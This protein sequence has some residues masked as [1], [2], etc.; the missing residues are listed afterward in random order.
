MAGRVSNVLKSR[1]DTTQK[2]KQKRKAHNGLN[3]LAIAE[4]QFPTKAKVRAHRLGE[5]E[6]FP[7]RKRDNEDDIADTK[8]RRTDDD[9]ASSG[10][11]GSDSD[12][13]EWKV[14][15][16][17][18]DDDSDIDSDEA[19]GSSDEER[20]EDFTFRG[21]ST[22]PK[23]KSK[24]KPN[25]VR[26]GDID[27]SEGSESDA[28]SG[29]DDEDFDDDLGEDA[30][31]LA[32]AWDM[33]A[34]ED[35]SD[36]EVSTKKKKPAPVHEPSDSAASDSESEGDSDDEEES[37]SDSDTDLSVSDDERDGKGDGLSKLQ[38]FVSSLGTGNDKV[39]SQ[40]Q[41][42]GQENGVPTEYGLTS[43]KK[44]TVSD[45]LS[46]VTDSRL[47]GSLKHLSSAPAAKGASSG[48]HG[49]LTAPLSKR[50]QDKIDRAAAYEKSKETLNRWID[51]VK[52]NREAEHISFPLPDP[53]EQQVARLGPVEPKTDLES[54]IQSI[55][56]ES[57][58]ATGEK[59]AEKQFQAAE[60][61]ETRKMSL[62]EV[63]A[64][65][66]EL[67]KRRDLLFREEIRAKRLKKIKS[68]SYRRVHRKEREKMEEVERQALIEA[69]IDPDEQERELFDRRRAE[70]RMGT[71]HKDSK[72]AKS[73]KETGRAAWDD[74]ARSSMNDMARRDEE[75]QRRI[76]G[77]NVKTGD[78]D[79][80][81]SSSSESE[82]EADAW[83][84]EADSEAEARRINRDLDALDD[85]V[86]SELAGPHSKLLSMSFMQKAEA[87]R[88]QQNEEEIKKLRRE[89]NGDEEDLSEEEEGGR[90][91]FGAS[92]PTVM[93]D[94]ARSR[95]KNEF[96]ETI[97]S[98]DE[99]LENE[100]T[101]GGTTTGFAKSKAKPK[102]GTVSKP[103]KAKESRP[104]IE[105]AEKEEVENPWLVQ[106]TRTN[107]KRNTDDADQGI[108]I[109][110]DD[111]EQT[112]AANGNKASSGQKSQKPKTQKPRVTIQKEDSGSDSDGDDAPV[113]LT[114]HDLVKRAFAGDDV[115][116]D[117]EREKEEAIEEEGDKI[118]DNTLPGWGSW[119][120]AGI[121][122]KQQKR[123]KRFLT[124]VEGIK[125]E[126]RKDAKLGHVIINEKRVKKNVKYM[127]TQLPHPFE[128]KQQYERSLRQ[129]IGPEWSTSDTFHE[130][131]KPRVVRHGRW[132][133][134]SPPI[135]PDSIP[136]HAY[137]FNPA[138]NGIL[139]TLTHS[140]LN[141]IPS[142]NLQRY[143]VQVTSGHPYLTP[144]PTAYSIPKSTPVSKSATSFRTLYPP[145]S[146]RLTN[147][148]TQGIYESRL[149]TEGHPS[150]PPF[151]YPSISL[152]SIQSLGDF[153]SS[154]SFIIPFAAV[155]TTTVVETITVTVSAN[156][157]IL[158][159]RTSL[160]AL[161][162]SLG[163]QAPSHS[164]TKSPASL[165]RM[166]AQD[167]F[168]TVSLDAVPTNIATKED[169]PVP[170]TGI[171]N[172]TSPIETNKFYAN[173]FLENQTTSS[174]T[175]PYSL[176]WCRGVGN[177]ASWGLAISH[178]DIDQLVYGNQ[179]QVLPG[180]PVEYYL[181]P[182]GLQSIALS[183]S[184][185]GNS[186]VLNTDRL[187][188]FSADVIL[189]PS[190]QSSQSITFPVLQGMGFVTGIYQGLQPL[191]QSSI[192]F[193][194]LVCIGAVGQGSYKYRVTLEDGKSWLFYVT[195]DNDNGVLPDFNFT[196]S[197]T[198]QG[199]GNFSGILQVAK[200]PAGDVGEGVYDRS[201][202]VYARSASISGVV[203]NSTATYQLTWD[204]VGHNSNTSL[205]MFALPHHIE[206]FDAQTRAGLQPV[207]LRSTT[208]GNMTAVA[209]DSWT[210]I[211]DELPIDIDFA[212]WSPRF[213]KIDQLS[214]DVQQTIRAAADSELTPDVDGQ[215]NLNSMYYSG[216][217]LSK[218][219]TLVYT[220]HTLADD[221]DRASATLDGLKKA[222]ARF[223]NNEQQFPLAYDESWKGV[224]S[225]AA[226][227]TNDLNQDFGNSGYND[228][229][230]HYGYFIHAAA[231]IGTL[232][233]SWIDSNKAWVNMLVRD[234]GNPAT[235][236]PSFPFSRAFDWF[237]GHSWAKGLFA[238]A[239]GKDQ[240]STSE[241]AM[242][243][244]AIKMWGKT[245]GDKSMEARGNLML[246]LLRRSFKNYFLMEDGNSNH[247]SNFC[248]NK[249][250][251][252]LFENK[253]HHTTYFGT[254]LEFIQGIHMLPLLPSS[255]YTRNETFVK[256]EWDAMFATNSCTPASTVTSGGWKGVLYANYAIIDPRE[257]YDFFNTSGF[258]M[259]WIDG[260]ATRTWYLAYAA[261]RLNDHEMLEM[262]SLSIRRK[263]STRLNDHEML[264]MPSLSIR[265]KQS[266]TLKKTTLQIPVCDTAA[267]AMPSF[268]GPCLRCYD[269]KRKRSRMSHVVEETSYPNVLFFTQASRLA[270]SRKRG[271]HG[272]TRITG[273]CRRSGCVPA[274]AGV[275]YTRY[276]A[277]PPPVHGR[278][279]GN[280]APVRLCKLAAS[281][282]G[283]SLLASLIAH[284]SVLQ[285]LVAQWRCL[286]D[287]GEPTPLHPTAPNTS[288][289]SS[290]RNIFR[291][292]HRVGSTQSSMTRNGSIDV[293]ERSSLLLHPRT[294]HE[295]RLPPASPYLDDPRFWVR[296]PAH[297]AYLTWATLASNYV[298]LLLV[299]VPLGIV[300]G[301]L[302]WSP[303]TVFTLNFLAI[304]PLAS[305]LSF[306]TEELA[307][308]MGQTLGGL[309]N[310]T[311]GNAVELIVSI[312]ALKDNQIRVVQASMLGSI[313][314]NIL[315]VLG[316]C[317]L[318]GGIRFPE[319][320]FNTTVASTMSSLMAVA[321]ASLI[322]PA[323]LFAAMSDSYNTAPENTRNS[324]LLL[325]R[326][327]AIILLVLYVL[328][329]VFQLK[330]HSRFFEDQQSAVVEAE[331]GAAEAEPEAEDHILNPFAAGV[332]LIVITIMVA[333][334][335]EYLVGSIEGMVEKTGM[336]KTFI[337]LV[338]IP[339]VGNAAEHVTAVVVAY[340][341]KMD[342]AIGVAIGSSLQIALF[343]TPFLVILGWI[344]GVD[345]TLHFHIFETVS[346]FISALVVIFLIQD[347]KSNYLE[348]GL[349]LGMYIILAI[350]FYVYPDDT[351]N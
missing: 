25:T 141:S 17:D 264:E 119:T 172:T 9:E 233:P 61:L 26:R 12:G 50:Q 194:D 193:R 313:L 349:C 263:Q 296:W 297:V 86:D 47:K 250:T 241:D 143:T 255:A 203:S 351:V 173:F 110:V 299:F 350:A 236:D 245:I 190:N 282:W 53:Y 187:T 90:R 136:K 29:D 83:D 238:S 188:G 293:H 27:L 286:A 231:I 153:T 19:L 40:K 182:V 78:E 196:S 132:W 55:L 92:K 48:S 307:A 171:V 200:N 85:Q 344:M 209:A 144:S 266:T 232:D 36:N 276:D 158:S 228:H 122:K 128:N 11:Y 15:Q 285:S 210:M 77:R 81:G 224:V 258:N 73:L 311:F 197:T 248:D 54:T 325:S 30:V 71:K 346:F 28:K 150:L 239:D 126:Q 164:A 32:T 301:V 219:A 295:E 87:S 323:S 142:I 169:H 113:L 115:V 112:A 289:S 186:T 159:L 163:I 237:H 305:L 272:I 91:K 95:S 44:L 145:Q 213:G 191:V 320:E 7:K 345:M 212:P 304:I 343:V 94:P 227:E 279:N 162:S 69:G 220:V 334:C 3:A 49:K 151:P 314:S 317:F 134:A 80:L 268:S 155:K 348:G 288:S 336:S 324:I 267:Q 52:A 35:E 66:A 328:Y 129:P 64:R 316:C 104:I 249:V 56:V 70:A 273:M 101:E 105:E 148:Q 98:E 340:K 127:A 57:G 34:Q 65:T 108:N 58:L 99:D 257:S 235:N 8:R 10:D 278:A 337:G 335:A 168:E 180:R 265:R 183:A 195:P 170:R 322:I 93:Q 277:D 68:K 82:D 46:S 174:F 102:V 42:H 72:W 116:E 318:I 192:I 21:S 24:R 251:G 275:K 114:N 207:Q 292:F 300:S 179:S 225:S 184:E 214:S 330:T 234:A 310:A 33:N 256:Q 41:T 223:V 38:D 5:V 252:I 206:S 303:A 222:F 242:F 139:F 120:G 201:A 270:E 18:S 291:A 342:L 147:I 290:T 160:P 181:N 308:V 326:G 312:V 177:A 137:V 283:F 117:F 111:Q 63:R 198:I 271:G 347:G 284:S 261:A 89:A 97:A 100:A 133:G 88:K 152:D 202:G 138:G 22:K 230:F 302:Q 274:Y 79:Y 269:K 2:P 309:M 218:F 319:Q 125:P 167:V 96:E 329:L 221:P 333:I 124:K 246:A 74:D 176:A 240:E 4:D 341:N 37:D 67:R 204:K 287:P 118:I 140:F 226:Y 14:G 211:E 109:A 321:S 244:Y 216:K 254:N 121:S 107:R 247:P 339:I 205:L 208:K 131:T 146:A 217:V 45:L 51:T 331:A 59:S 243:A 154:Q 199:P 43:A 106:N 332:A 185:L 62:E 6:D 338:L 178:T 229:H 315:L 84:E 130:S 253:A 166:D 298:N 161:L 1:N 31:D 294:V 259:T 306:A 189:R 156:P 60:E 281:F 149:E 75:L 260:G 280:A 157:A 165:Q 20:F 76:E 262:P 135:G 103:T 123:Q 327:T 215:S 175:Q 39:K 23:T 16:V 13:H